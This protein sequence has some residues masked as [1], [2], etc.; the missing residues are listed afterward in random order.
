MTRRTGRSVRWRSIDGTPHA[1]IGRAS[2]AF[3]LIELLVVISIIA[4]LIALLLPSLSRAREQAKSVACLANLKGI[5]T[6]SITYA[7]SDQSEQALPVHDLTGVAGRDPAVY[8]WGGKS[9]R[10]DG[11]AGMP[12]D[13]ANSLW[14]TQLG[15]GPATRPLNR[16]LYK[17]D[18]ANFQLTPGEDNANW[19]NDAQMDMKIVKCPSDRGYTGHHLASWKQSGLSSYDH[20]GTSYAAN[21]TWCNGHVDVENLFRSWSPLFRPMSRIP[22]TANTIYYMENCGRFGWRATTEESEICFTGRDGPYFIPTEGVTDVMGW[23]KR[24]FH[25][26]AAMVDGSA[27]TI[28]MEGYIYPAPRIEFSVGGSPQLTACHVLRGKDWQLDVLPSPPID[29]II[30]QDLTSWPGNALR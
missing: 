22:N 7:F 13:L 30:D 1:G 8:D 15:R 24:P 29:R 26:N 3:T 21:A 10:G 27:R 11:M 4:L 6:A 9:G 23:H 17:A 12:S 14:G 28:R 5:A 16:V 2:R 19:R 18:F 20:Y 25:F